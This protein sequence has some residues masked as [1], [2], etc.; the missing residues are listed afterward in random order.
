MSAPAPASP[1]PDDPVVAP[2]ARARFV[3]AVMPTEDGRYL[4][5]QRDDKPGIHAPGALGLFGGGVEPGESDEAAFR[6]EIAEELGYVPPPARYWRTLHFALEREADGG[7]RMAT[8]VLYELPIAA[9]A[10]P[11]LRQTEG[12]GRV[13]IAPQLLWLAPRVSRVA[14]LAVGEHAQAMLA[15]AARP[16]ATQFWPAEAPGEE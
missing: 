6:R 11:R 13:L 8:V 4:L 7:L 1:P 15:G 14:L 16:G 12:V 10:V 3:G 9:R 5:Q 2:G